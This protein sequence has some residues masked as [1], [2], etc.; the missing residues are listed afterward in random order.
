MHT[1]N[2][3]RMWF[4]ES[5]L[6]TDALAK[7]KEAN[8]PAI[9]KIIV[10]R[11]KELFIETGET[12]LNLPKRYIKEVILK[13]NNKYEDHYIGKSLN[14]LGVEQYKNEQGKIVYKRFSVPYYQ[15]Y[16]GQCEMKEER[17]RPYVFER[18][19]FITQEELEQYEIKTPDETPETNFNSPYTQTGAFD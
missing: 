12:T 16:S 13:S 4:R 19:K 6:E 17:G 7:L 1:Q 5:L 9:E 2:E 8:R 3:T 15:E 18:D 10:E 11:I 14:N